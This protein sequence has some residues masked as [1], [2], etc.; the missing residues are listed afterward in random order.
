MA[1]WI[2]DSSLALVDLPAAIL[3][4]KKCS[5]RHSVH[6]LKITLVFERRC[7]HV[8]GVS[9]A[10]TEPHYASLASLAGR[11]NSVLSI[12]HRISGKAY[13]AP[14]SLASTPVID[15]PSTISLQCPGSSV[16][17]R[18]GDGMAVLLKAGAAF[19]T[20]RVGARQ[21]LPRP[22]RRWSCGFSSTRFGGGGDPLGLTPSVHGASEWCPF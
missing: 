18:R 6:L 21:L 13:S 14:R 4:Q 17:R 2:V 12:R 7:I 15:T 19:R 16:H 8:R 20:G 5:V 3:P 1:L 22:E 11:G 10:A 9:L